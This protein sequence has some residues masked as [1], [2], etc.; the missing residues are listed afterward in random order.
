[1]FQDTPG[2]PQR[3]FYGY[4]DGLHA[5]TVTDKPGYLVSTASPPPSGTPTHPFLELVAHQ[6]FNEGEIATLLKQ[7]S[8]FD[9]YIA[10]LLNAGYDIASDDTLSGKSPGVGVRLLAD[11]VPVGAAWQSG[12]QFT[13]LWWQPLAGEMVFKPARLTIYLPVWEERL[14]TS[15]QAAGSYEDFC[16]NVQGQGLKLGN[17]RIRSW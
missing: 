9:D 17:F 6:A 4:K 15:L 10:L 3:C 14:Y 7:A 2:R 1:M 12:G 16:N 13:C 5:F 8:S 11:D